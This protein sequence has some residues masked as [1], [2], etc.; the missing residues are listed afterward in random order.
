MKYKVLTMMLCATLLIPNFGGMGAFCDEDVLEQVAAEEVV[1]IED[2]EQ[3]I[4]LEDT[5]EVPEEDVSEEDTEEEIIG[6]EITVIYHTDTKYSPETPCQ[7]SGNFDIPKGFNLSAYVQIMN[8]DGL[9]YQI[10]ASDENDYVDYA[11]LPE[12]NY[13]VL[14][15][16][17]M[18]DIK[19]EYPMTLFTEDNFTLKNDGRNTT[20]TIQID[21]Y[22]AIAKTI[23]ERGGNDGVVQKPR[24]DRNDYEIDYYDDSD[25]VRGITLYDT[26]FDN[27]KM[28]ADGKLYYDV[29]SSKG[30]YVQCYGYAERDYD[31]VLEVIES[32]YFEEARVAVYL[33]GKDGGVAG[34]E[35]LSK[36]YP[37]P[38]LGL[39]FYFDVADDY[40]FEEGQTFEV[41]VP[42]YVDFRSDKVRDD[43]ANLVA[44]LDKNTV[45]DDFFLNVEVIADG[46]YG[47]AKLSI[48]KDLDTENRTIATI[49]EDGIVEYEGFTFYFGNGNYNRGAAWTL[50]YKYVADEANYA[51]LYVL[52]VLAGLLLLG[53]Y[54]FLATQKEKQSDYQINTWVDRQDEKSY[55]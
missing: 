13:I 2:G 10:T 33:D 20:I 24:Y 40:V 49:G 3:D 52:G 34:Y 46:G 48:V 12:G 43:N 19:N 51:P 55:E 54:V 44:T 25:A 15:Y 53:G 38:G 42:K 17:I 23:V 41:K 6:D 22:D 27:I 7:V 14:S 32:G 16:G 11:F 21:D 47:Q 30:E 4:P 8:E 18:G 39:D 29:K 28:G 26:Y 31:I 35:Y 37:Q 5:V 1:E 36:E 45:N 9:T 50:D